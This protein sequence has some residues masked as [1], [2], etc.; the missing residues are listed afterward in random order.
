MTDNIAAREQA[1]LQPSA[2]LAM[3]QS[4]KAATAAG[5]PASGR[6]LPVG[7]L[8]AFV[9]LL[10]LWHHSTLAYVATGLAKTAFNKP[11]FIWGAFPIEDP[12][13]FAPFG[14]IAGY[15]DVFF[16]S[17]MFFVSGLFVTDSLKRKGA[18]GFMRDRIVRLGIPFAVCAAILAPLAY[19]PAY[20]SRGGT[21]STFI[22]AWLS[23]PQ[24]FSGPAWFL[25]VLLAYGAVAAGLWAVAPR[26][27]PALGRICGAAGQRPIVFYAGLAGVSA[28]AYFVMIHAFDSSSWFNWGPFTIQKGRVIHYAVYFFAGIGVGAAGLEQGLLAAGGRL[29]RRWPVW[30]GAS[31][32]AFAAI[33]AFLV[34]AILAKGQPRLLWDG[35]GAPL[36]AL[37]C[38]A[39]CF[40]VTGIFLRFA[41]KRTAVWDSLANNAYGMYLTHYVF[42]AWVQYA[43]LSLALPGLVKG[44]MVFTSVV[45]LSWGVTMLLRRAPLAR[46]VL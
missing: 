39:S 26:A 10:V 8:R 7:Y 1:V 23:L 35:F 33:G 41:T 4:G 3:Q 24:W 38:A 9:T 27:F 29:A 30:L 20:L 18:T 19:M 34:A 42:A 21:V 37:A 45:A 40:A 31:V 5:A 17:L 15:N 6:N 43:L 2:A 36:F 32:L 11:P 12:H 13:S 28:L 16:M 46:H 25:W 44:L 22:P 14:I